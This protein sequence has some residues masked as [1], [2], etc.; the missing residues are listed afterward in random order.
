[1]MVMNAVLVGFWKYEGLQNYQDHK[2][3]LQVG[4]PRWIVRVK[5]VLVGTAAVQNLRLVIAESGG[6][7]KVFATWVTIAKKCQMTRRHRAHNPRFPNWFSTHA[8]V[9]PQLT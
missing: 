4:I 3:D 6:E 8:V 1:M 5:R 2:W 7:W 9:R